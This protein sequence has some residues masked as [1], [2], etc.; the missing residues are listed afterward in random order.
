MNGKVLE[1]LLCLYM[2]GGRGVCGES[3]DS[4]H[5]AARGDQQ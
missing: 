4:D 1:E 2:D 3:D 5:R